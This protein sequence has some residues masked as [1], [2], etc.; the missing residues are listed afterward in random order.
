MGSNLTFEEAVRYGQ[1]NVIAEHSQGQ[2]LEVMNAQAEVTKQHRRLE[3]LD[4]QLGFAQELFDQIE[5]VAN[6]ETRAAALKKRIAIA[7][8]NSMFE[9]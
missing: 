3:L 9:R 1:L 7:F 6:E 2:L 8:D 5:K 4:E